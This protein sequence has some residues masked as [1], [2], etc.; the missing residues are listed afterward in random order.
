MIML[1]SS[2]TLIS[3]PISLLAN[4]TYKYASK[5]HLIPSAGADLEASLSHP[6]SARAEAERRRFVVS[7]LSRNVDDNFIFQGDGVEST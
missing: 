1:S 2:H 3:T 7:S 6:G 5:F 4:T